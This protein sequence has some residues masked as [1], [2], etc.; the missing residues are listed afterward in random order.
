MDGSGVGGGVG[1]GPFASEGSGVWLG[2]GVTVEPHAPVII[3]TRARATTVR[4]V[5]G[6]IRGMVACPANV[7]LSAMSACGVGESARTRSRS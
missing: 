5:A 3:P 6:I 1:G 2:A 4:A 7:T